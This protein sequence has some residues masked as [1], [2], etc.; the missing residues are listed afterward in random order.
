M[1]ASKSHVINCTVNIFILCT[2][3]LN[4]NIISIK[5]IFIPQSMKGR[6]EVFRIHA[7]KNFRD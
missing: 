2:M 3:S 1:R 4:K 6:N 7:F 5:N